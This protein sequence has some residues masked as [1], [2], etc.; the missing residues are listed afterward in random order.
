MSGWTVPGYTETGNLGAGATGRVVSAVQDATG[1]QVAIKYLSPRF[2]NNPEFV[3]RFRDEAALLAEIEHP[4]VVRLYEYV[5]TEA[6]SAMVMELVPGPTLHRVLHE[7]GR[8]GPEAALSVMRGSLLGLGTA[9]QVGIVHRDYKP[10][11]VLLNAY[12]VS[13]LADF[14]VAERAVLTDPEDPDA[15]MPGGT[16]TPAYMAPEQWDGAP[17]RPVTDIYAVTASF[18]ECLTGKVPYSADTIYDLQEKH[19]TAPIP[20]AEVPEQV[21][22]LITHGLAKDPAERPQDVGAFVAEV[23]HTAAEVYGVDWEERGRQEIVALWPM[24]PVFGGV[25]GLGGAAGGLDMLGLAPSE[26]GEA[27]ELSAEGGEEPEGGPHVL[28]KKVKAGGIAVGV[29]VVLVVIA[30]IAAFAGGDKNDKTA[31]PASGT[32]TVFTP[33]PSEPTGTST[34]SDFGAGPTGASSGSA[35]SSSSGSRSSTSSSSRSSSSSAPSSHPSSSHASTPASTPT[36]S[37]PTS[38]PSTPP[39][40]SPL[41]DSSS[42]PQM[43]ITAEMA[44]PPDVKGGNCSYTVTYTVTFKITNPPNGS[45]SVDYIWHLAS[46]GTIDEGP[47]TMKAGIFTYTTS[48]KLRSAV[49]DAYVSWTANSTRGRSNSV[50]VAATCIT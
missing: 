6:G 2:A 21:Q 39:P 44:D 20:V 24:L 36:L 47:V 28:R 23:E 11:N 13:K 3:E 14:G 18:F 17:A 49:T 8:M 31:A 7:K 16:G 43:K 12:G 1:T 30:M 35:S 4:N 29:A 41:S 5:E 48:E 27:R 38:I 33:T 45:V 40:S 15:T 34:S 42:T 37:S 19:R 50:S 25:G 26:G 22:A 46:G 9:H 10:S 32:A